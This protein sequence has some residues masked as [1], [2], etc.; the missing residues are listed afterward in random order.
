MNRDLSEADDRELERLAYSRADTP[1]RV[2]LADAA[3]QELARRAD[4][5]AAE[6]ASAELAAR[7]ANP[8]EQNERESASDDAED[9][10]RRRMRAVGVAGVI[11]ALLAI[12][13]VGWALALPDPDP[14]AIF[15]EPESQEDREWAERLS[16]GFASYITQGPRVTPLGNDR[17][18]IVYRASTV[19]DGRS[20][21]WDLYCIAVADLPEES[22]GWSAG[23]LCVLPSVFEESG[24]VASSGGNTAGP[25]LFA[26]GPAGSPRLEDSQSLHG[27]EQAPSV[28]D[29]IAFG[30]YGGS[31]VVEAFDDIDEPDRLLMGPSAVYV[32]R[33]AEGSGADF[34]A[35][36]IDSIELD[37]EP[38][39][40]LRARHPEVPS[41]TSCGPLS[42]VERRGLTVQL[43]TPESVWTVG[44]NTDGSINSSTFP[45]AA[46]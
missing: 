3:A 37:G 2:S 11:S 34:S 26:W 43:R 24:V 38:E 23:G 9:G 19:P 36:L 33:E 39:Y 10:R 4:V 5:A 17:F 31:P 41:A 13:T 25:G 6:R 35:F 8:P 45:L 20:T 30:A 46:D 29:V 21:E 28:L 18:G 27:N 40:C 14:L 1:E 32:S 42:R 12:P 7:I 16:Q 44:V 15:D 22:E